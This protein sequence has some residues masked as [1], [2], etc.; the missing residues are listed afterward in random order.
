MSP[1]VLQEEFVTNVTG[2]VLVSQTFLP[3]IEKSA[4]KMIVN[5]SS[6]LGSIGAGLDVRYSSYSVTKTAL[7]M[8]VSDLRT[9]N[10]DLQQP[11][12]EVSCVAYRRTSRLLNDPTS[13]SSRLTLVGRRLVRL[14]CSVV[15]FRLGQYTH[16]LSCRAWWS[17]GSRRS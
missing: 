16:A 10:C 2:P 4:R 12:E 5:V 15:S 1:E 9:P 14:R 7:N 13:R 3:L 6:L 11:A 8:F 17:R